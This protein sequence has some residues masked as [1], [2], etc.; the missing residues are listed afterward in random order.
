[1]NQRLVYVYQFVILN[2]NSKLERFNCVEKYTK[3]MKKCR[4]SRNYW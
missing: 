4:D 3:T 1:M 2:K